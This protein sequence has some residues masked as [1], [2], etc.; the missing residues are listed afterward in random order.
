MSETLDEIL[1]ELVTKAMDEDM[2]D[3]WKDLYKARILAAVAMEP[4]SAPEYHLTAEGMTKLLE[5]ALSNL[6]KPV[7]EHAV[8]RLS[9]G[10]LADV[11]QQWSDGGWELVTMTYRLIIPLAGGY[12]GEYVCVFRREKL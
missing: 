4:K 1:V 2:Y 9:E 11:V 3:P 10:N 5:H 8:Q 7:Y 6:P 12:S